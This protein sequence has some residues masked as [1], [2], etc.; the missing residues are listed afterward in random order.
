MKKYIAKTNISI[1]VVLGSGANRHIAFDALTCGG[2]VFYTDDP[3]LQRAIE[4]HYK[5]GSLFRLSQETD[6]HGSTGHIEGTASDADETATTTGLDGGETESDR[7]KPVVVSDPDSAK[8][9]LADHFGIS[10]TKLKTIK[11]I[12]EAAAANGI[13]FQGI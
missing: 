12:K 4:R 3:E 10:R 5:F 8:A 6:G 11:A 1:N 2:S 7:L 13:S 9:Y